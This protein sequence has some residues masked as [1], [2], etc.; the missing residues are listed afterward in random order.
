VRYFYQVS[1]ANEIGASAWTA[2]IQVIAMQALD[3][4]AAWQQ[5]NVLGGQNGPMQNPDGDTALNLLEF[6]LGEDPASGG[7]AQDRFRLVGN[8]LGGVDA[9]LTRPEGRTGVTMQLMMS[10]ALS[11]SMAWVVA[12]LNPLVTRN[13]D[14]TETLQ[15]A[16]LDQMLGLSNAGRGFVR[17]EV[18]L[19]SSGEK[20]STATWFWDRRGFPQGIQS[21]GPAM[22]QRERFSGR[23]SAGSVFL[24]VGA[25]TGGVSVSGR[26]DWSRPAFLEVVDGVHEG[27]R[28]EID[29]AQTTATRLALNANSMRNTRSSVPELAGA[30]FVV[31]DHWTLENLFPSNVWTGATSPVEADRVR[32]YD[33]GTN[34]WQ[35]FWLGDF[36]SV[37]R[38]VLQ[39]DGSLADQGAVVVPPGAGTLVQRVGLEKQVTFFGVLRANAFALPASA[40]TTFL[41]GG[42]P[43]DQSPT[44]RS[45]LFAD[46]FRASN[47]PALADRILLWTPDRDSRATQGYDAF[48][49]L[50]AGQTKAFWASSSSSNVQDLNQTI[51]FG[52]HRA[53]FVKLQSAK[54]TW[55]WPMPWIP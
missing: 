6:A 9:I 51:L 25:S 24:D 53:F 14:G 33:S 4:W 38:W 12:G 3:T 42:W 45:M 46:G 41:A 43:V 52:A 26:L 8:G 10:S 7:A 16:S 50:G 2:P 39:G 15:F 28:F 44:D 36:R 27:H 11:R 17:V 35:S 20:A 29:H 30:R 1:A 54:P 34:A 32:F 31:R 40:G 19:Q 22:L 47:N 55:K 48:F 13:G 18:T 37:R 21:F 5:A 23:V 49:L